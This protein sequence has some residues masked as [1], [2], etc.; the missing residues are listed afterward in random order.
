[1]TSMSTHD[2]TISTHFVPGLVALSVFVAALAG[3]IALDLIQRSATART[4]VRRIL[5]GVGGVTMGLGIW[6]MHFIGMLSLHMSMPASYDVG[7][8]ALSMLAAILG[9]VVALTI[10][11]RARARIL[12][13]FTAATFMALA[14]AAMHYLGMASMEMQAT[15]SWNLPLVV[16][17]VLIGFAA[18]FFALWL[19][20]M[21]GRE[22]FQLSVRVRLGAATLLGVGVA[23]LHYTGMLAATF[24]ATRMSA[25]AAGASAIG[26]GWI[27]A[28]LVVGAGIMLAVVIGGAAADRRR[29]DLATDLWRVAAIARELGHK[30]GARERACAAAVEVT[31]ADFAALLERGEDGREA[32]TGTAGDL[33][34]SQYE[35]EPTGSAHDLTPLTADP[36]LVALGDHPGRDFSADLEGRPAGRLGVDAVLGTTLMRDGHPAGVLVLTWKG[37][38]HDLGERT[39]SLLDLLISEAAIAIDREDLIAR[40][41]YMARRDALTGLANRRTLQHE[42]ERAITRAEAAG[43]PLSLVMLDVDK[44]KEHNDLHGHQAGDRVLKTAAGSWSQLLGPGDTLARYGGDEF[45]AILPGTGLPDALKLAERMR[46][47]VGS[48]VTASV[49]VAEW[50]GS[51]SGAR[52]ISAADAALYD[53]K[54][55][56]RDQAFGLEPRL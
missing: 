52:L 35:R 32:V 34:G 41:D 11:A 18:S 24:H 12:D 21:I 31:G 19:V 46:T 26:S 47:A 37:H 28:L 22:R 51:Q 3:Y 33:R 4:N 40:L 25:E 50:D 2:L 36:V 1:M 13:L 29:A 9:S 5:I 56:G 8:V 45:I 53:A 10:V 43:E 54:R 16:L 44:F 49:G 42:L 15:I 55:A 17:S 48:G 23:G 30:E 38:D 39:R 6:S 14:I 20:M 27:I 7:L